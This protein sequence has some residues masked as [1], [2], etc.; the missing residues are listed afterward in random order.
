MYQSLHQSRRIC[1]HRDAADPLALTGEEFTLAI[2]RLGMS[3]RDV[4]DTFGVTRWDVR[5]WESGA[6][7]APLVVALALREEIDEQD[8]EIERQVARLSDV[9]D[10]Q[11]ENRRG[12]MEG[13]TFKWWHH[14][15]REVV[16]RSGRA[17]IVHVE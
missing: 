7:T 9:A 17:L 1:F 6:E 4:A 3:T 16:L 15:A 14:V 13:H 8:Q 10:P 5:E 12:G 2:R 11:F